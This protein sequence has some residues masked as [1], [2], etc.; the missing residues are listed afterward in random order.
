MQQQQ[1]QS[2]VAAPAEGGNAAAAWDGNMG[3]PAPLAGAGQQL[4]DAE[5]T[6]P[7]S[8]IELSPLF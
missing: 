5:L 7:D 2:G 4:V 1:Q 8:D 6:S 3:T